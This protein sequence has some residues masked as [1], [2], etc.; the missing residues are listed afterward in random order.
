VE[1]WGSGGLERFVIAEKHEHISRVATKAKVKV[2]RFARRIL[3]CEGV[4]EHVDLTK[5]R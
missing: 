2:A 5:S 3:L 4:T 1:I